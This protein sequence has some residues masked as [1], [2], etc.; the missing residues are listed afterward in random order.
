MNRELDKLRGT[1]LHNG[2]GD[3]SVDATGADAAFYAEVA[4]LPPRCAPAVAHKPIIGG[5]EKFFLG[6]KA[7]HKHSVV[8]LSLGA[9]AAGQDAVMLELQF[10]SVKRNTERGSGGKLLRNHRFVRRD[11]CPALDVRRLG[12][13][14]AAG[15]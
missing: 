5:F 3:L 1:C 10:A 9:K 2:G 4:V 15:V 7:D 11:G 6:T 8:K 12:Q 14:L 13:V